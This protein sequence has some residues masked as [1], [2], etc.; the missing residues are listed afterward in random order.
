MFKKSIVVI[1]LLTTNLAYASSCKS[2]SAL[3]N[4]KMA[5]YS[6]PDFPSLL[7]DCGLNDLIGKFGGELF[8]SFKIDMPDFSVCGYNTKDMASWFGVD[9]NGSIGVDGKVSFGGQLDAKSLINGNTKIF[10]G[11][12]KFS[13][14]KFNE[15][16]N[17]KIK[18]D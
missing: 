14:G 12:F 2:P 3:H 8:N 1:C 7:E 13:D 18:L 16:G 17:L 6:M 9:Y 10:D 11:G 15:S 5:K 4:E